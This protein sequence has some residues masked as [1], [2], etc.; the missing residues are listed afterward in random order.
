MQQTSVRLMSTTFYNKTVT[1]LAL[2]K[3]KRVTGVTPFKYSDTQKHCKE[4]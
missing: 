3:N 2:V 1:L 4:L